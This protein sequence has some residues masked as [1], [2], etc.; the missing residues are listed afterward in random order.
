MVETRICKYSIWSITKVDTG[1]WHKTSSDIEDYNAF[2]D[3]RETSSAWLGTYSR[4]NLRP[5]MYAFQVLFYASTGR[6]AYVSS[7]G[8]SKTQTQTVDM[9]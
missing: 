5:L 3:R 8:Q 1:R 7:S 2:P 6:S 4:S 9:G